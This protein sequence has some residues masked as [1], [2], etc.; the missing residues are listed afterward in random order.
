MTARGRRIGQLVGALVVLGLAIVW[1][2]DAWWDLVAP[3]GNPRNA[4]RLPE[5]PAELRLVAEGFREITDLQAVP[6]PWP[7]TWLVVLERPGTAVLVDTATDRRTV[8]FALEVATSSEEGLLGLAFDPDFAT[9]RRFY[10]NA[11]IAKDQGDFTRI[12]AWTWPTDPWSGARAVRD[13]ALVEFEQPYA[14]HNGGQL[15]FGADRMLYIATGDGGSGG[16]PHKNGQNPGSWLGKILRIDPHRAKGGR[17]YAIPADNPFVGR[18]GFRPEIWA[19]GLRNPWR[20][21]FDGQGRLWIA[22]VGQSHAEEIDLGR[23]GANYGWNV[24]EGW[25][26]CVPTLG[27]SGKLH[28]ETCTQDS[29]CLYGQCMFG[30]PIAFYDKSIGVCTKNCGYVGGGSNYIACGSE[31]DNPTG[32]TYKCVTE[33]TTAV[34]NTKQDKTLPNVYKMCVRTCLKDDDCAKWNPA[35]PNCVKSSTNELSTPPVGVCV[36]SK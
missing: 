34:G 7:D 3:P 5:C 11:V 25:F 12:D 9:N 4:P 8:V 19:L 6:A 1:R 30:L 10:T 2:L 18:A 32:A 31:D 20:M 13:G 36:K 17:A 16:D 14:N 35:L 23:A 24:R 21:S 28:G 33:K 29:D 22:D 26:N 27:K 15:V